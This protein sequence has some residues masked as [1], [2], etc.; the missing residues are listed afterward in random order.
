MVISRSVFCWQC[1]IDRCLNLSAIWAWT[2]R[3]LVS[4]CFVRWFLGSAWLRWST[5]GRGTGKTG[6]RR[7]GNRICQASSTNHTSSISKL[8]GDQRWLYR[9]RS[10]QSSRTRRSRSSSSTWARCAWAW[11]AC[12]WLD[13]KLPLPADPS[14]CSWSLA[15]RRQ[16]RRALQHTVGDVSS[17]RD[18]AAQS[19]PSSKNHS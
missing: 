2:G 19:T 17:C 15:L 14:R 8:L 7:R 12:A 3:T 11:F 1:K 5:F 16:Y 10:F 6:P 9:R 18:P 4:F 13:L